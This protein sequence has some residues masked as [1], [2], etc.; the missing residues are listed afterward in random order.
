VHQLVALAWLPNPDCL[1]QINHIN[2]VKLDN[3][4]ENLEWCTSK[5]NVAHALRTGLIDTRTPA[6]IA[7]AKI[8]V[9]KARAAQAAQRMFQ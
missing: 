4:V 5:H 6:K 1:P 7:A 3:H 8:N 2:G 9:V